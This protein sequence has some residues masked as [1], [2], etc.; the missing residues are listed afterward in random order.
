MGIFQSPTP[1]LWK[2]SLNRNETGFH[3]DSLLDATRAEMEAIAGQA[4]DVPSQLG[5]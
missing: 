4:M 1:I 5:G 3:V 2:S